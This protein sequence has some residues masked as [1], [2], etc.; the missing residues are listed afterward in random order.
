[1]GDYMKKT[2]IALIKYDMTE[3]SGGDRVAANLANALSDYFDVHL[4]S[5]N[6]KGESPYFS[7]SEKVTY[8]PLLAGHKRIRKTIIQGT[9][10]IR[11]YVKQNG[12]ELLMSIGGNVNFFMMNSSGKKVKKVFCEHINLISALKDPSDTAMRKLGAKKADKIVTLTEKDRD[13]YISHFSLCEERVVAIPNW[14]DPPLLD[15]N[16][17]YDISSKKIIT[18]GRLCDQKG[19][20]YLVEIAKKIFS[21]CPDWK[22]E[23]WGDGPDREKTQADIDKNGLSDNVVLRGTTDSIY[24]IYP[25][26]GFYSMTSRTEG[27]PMVLLEAK[28]RNL[29]IVSFDCLTGPS[30]IVEDGVSGYIIP[31]FDTDEFAKKMLSVMKNDSLRAEL[32]AHAKDNLSKFQKEQIV[33]RWVSLV[34]EMTR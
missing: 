12:I 29:P 27:L 22:W 5:I 6:G 24:N 15:Y 13:A 19:L 18:V 33:N 10:A 21:D 26:Y 25:E 31:T 17:E 32:A 9:L 8:A 14:I 2:S 28:T 1:M 30:D 11:K 3:K 34:E 16:G 7:V 20:D 23:I 4:I